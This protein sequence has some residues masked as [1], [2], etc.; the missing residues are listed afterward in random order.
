M[1]KKKKNEHY[2][3]KIIDPIT[4]QYY[5]GS[6]TCKCEPKADDYMGSYCTW[7]PEDESRLNKEILKVGFKSRKDALEYE[8]KIIEEH[9]DNPLNENYHIPPNNFYGSMVGKIHSE[10]SKKKMSEAHM[11]KVLSKEHIEKIK[12]ANKGINV[13]EK[14]GMYGMPSPFRGKNHT[15]KVIQQ[16]IKDRKDRFSLKWFKEKYGI[17]RGVEEYNKRCDRLSTRTEGKN[18]PRAR[19]IIHIESGKMFDTG[20]QA[21]DY[22]GVSNATVC[23]HCR[24]YYKIKKFDYVHKDAKNV[25]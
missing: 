2:V 24:G 17:E 4:K 5:I 6:R 14:N 23:A 9:I 16:M 10:E 3:Y 21:A 19:K 11:G 15:D 20:K 8:A 13:G 1:S 12:K 22:F 18:N 7:N 25:D